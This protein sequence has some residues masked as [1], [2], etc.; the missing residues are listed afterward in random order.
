MPELDLTPR[1]VDLLNAIACGRTAPQIA[2][3]TGETERVVKG[4]LYRLYRRLG[5]ERRGQKRTMAA[6]WAL[7]NG[8]L[9]R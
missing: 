8:V 7:E 6:V 1:E 4:R 2:R 5:I 3:H 9:R